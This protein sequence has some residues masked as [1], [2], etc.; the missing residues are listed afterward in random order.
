MHALLF[1]SSECK[2]EWLA[3]FLNT[4]SKVDQAHR[5]SALKRILE[6]QVL[7][8]ASCYRRGNWV[9]VSKVLGHFQGLKDTSKSGIDPFLSLSPKAVFV[10]LNYYITRIK[11]VDFVTELMHAH[12][13]SIIVFGRIASTHTISKLNTNPILPS[14]YHNVNHHQYQDYSSN[15]N[16]YQCTRHFVKHS[17]V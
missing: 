3:F 11:E 2:L 10:L 16:N 4:K 17:C 8:N 12:P 1:L 15:N 6:S 13:L 5:M 9:L 14:I 7:P